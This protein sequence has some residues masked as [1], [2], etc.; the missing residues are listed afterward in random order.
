M[1]VADTTQRASS[2]QTQAGATHALALPVAIALVSAAAL[3]WQ[4]LLMRWLAIAHWH[5][6]AVMII[7][8]ALLGHGASGTW[9]SV[10]LRGE[11]LARLHRDFDAAFATCALLF[12]TSAAI[13]LLVARAIP[14]NGL[15]L[16]WNPRQML[17]L[18]MLYLTLSVPFFFAAACF[19][20]AFARHGSRIPALYGADLIGAAI[21]TL[22]ALAASARPVE[23]GLL[24]AALCG[25]FAAVLVTRRIVLRMGALVVAI[26]L[27]ML[28]PTQALVPRANEFKGLSKALLLPESRVIARSSDPYGSFALVESPSV[29]LRFAPG[30]SLSHTDELPAQLAIYTDGDAMSPIVRDDSHMNWQ[31][32]DDMTSALPYRMRLPDRVLVLGTGGGMHVL[33]ALTLG[34]RHVDAVEQSARRLHWVREEFGAYSGRLLDD[35]RVS[36]FVAEP[37]AFVRAS[38]ERY[39]LVVLAGGE[40][41]ASG[42]AGVQSTSEQYALTTEALRDYLRALSPRGMLVV[43]QWSKQPPRDELKLFATAVD[44]L[45]SEGVRDP[46]R[47]VAAI[48]NWD[49]STWL[50]AR[51]AFDP[52]AIAALT[53]FAERRGFDVVHAPR[54]RVDAQARFHH[55]DPPTLYEGVQALL[56]PGARQYIDDY[57]FDIAPATDDRPYFSHFFR[58]RSL[59]ELWRLRGQGGAVLLDSGY[60]VL[61]AT[62][63]QAIVLAF[64]LVLL[65]LRALRR[66]SVAGAAL[67][68]RIGAYFLALGLAFL[69]IEIALLSRLT[70]LLGHPWIAANVGLAAMLLCAGLGSLQAQRWLSAP[71]VDDAAIARR[72]AWSVRAIVLGLAWQFVVLIA[73]HA[74]TASWSLWGRAAIAFVGIAPLAFAMGMPFPL[75]LARLSRTAPSFVPW[76]WGLN[77]CAS[78]VAAILALLLAISFGLRATLVIAL[79]LYVFAAWVWRP[80]AS[81]PRRQ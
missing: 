43:T 19:G 5:P 80:A 38:G 16:V 78:V 12:A 58:W 79:A 14:F 57:R 73:A 42:G 6:F 24:I 11:R 28:W 81:E 59:P 23:K 33:Q 63:V 41:F 69:L 49:A 9:L 30:L 60:L 32:L 53:R 36:N 62:L 77:G 10:W 66:E 70:L 47:N 52:H 68:L 21:G 20:L 76:A 64:A 54:W 25:P 71:N 65:P 17:W 2:T 31:W 67:R 22:A 34:A 7:S 18:A 46:S 48:R 45:R 15:E 75:G 40:S 35:R 55:L 72:I 44:A 3:A 26:A 27:A 56:S 51:S 39:D 61:V 50:V 37:R 4:L 29:P 1:S 13:T 74:L 8:L